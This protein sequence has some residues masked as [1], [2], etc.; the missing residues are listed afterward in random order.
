MEVHREHMIMKER[1]KWR[2]ERLLSRGP[3]RSAPGGASTADMAKKIQQQAEELKR[4]QGKLN[5]MPDDKK[6][7]GKGGARGAA[8]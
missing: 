3:G 6:G 5:A 8:G 7:D 4:L 1:R 2:E